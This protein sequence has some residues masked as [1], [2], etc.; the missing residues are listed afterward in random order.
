VVQ[1][2]SLKADVTFLR[3]METRSMCKPV[4]LA[5]IYDNFGAAINFFSED[6]NKP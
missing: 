1:L 4:V 5:Y 2:L 6:I 3:K